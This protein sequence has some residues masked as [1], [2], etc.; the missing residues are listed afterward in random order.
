MDLYCGGQH[1]PR[2]WTYI[3]GQREYF[4]VLFS[5]TPLLK[6]C[7][8][9]TASPMMQYSVVYTTYKFSI[10]P[11]SPYHPVGRTWHHKL[12]GDVTPLYIP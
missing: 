11:L 12:A 7:V 8:G 2:K 5:L 6:I 3:I 1:F 9:E 10:L 4:L